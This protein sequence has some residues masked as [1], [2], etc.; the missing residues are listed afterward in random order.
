MNALYKQKLFQF[1]AFFKLLI[2]MTL[3]LLM[4]SFFYFAP[5]NGASLVHF[6]FYGEDGNGSLA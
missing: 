5:K 6:V 1:G 3:F 4:R 2:Y